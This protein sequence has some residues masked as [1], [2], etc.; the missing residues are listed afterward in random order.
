MPSLRIKHTFRL[1][2]RFQ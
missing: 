2:W 1:R